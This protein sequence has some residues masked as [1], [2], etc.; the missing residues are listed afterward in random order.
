MFTNSIKDSC[1]LSP[2]KSEGTG[3]IQFAS[4]R[5]LLRNVC[6]KDL[7]SIMEL[8][9]D[10]RIAEMMNGSIP[11]PYSINDA[12]EWVLK[13]LSDSSSSLSISWAIIEKEKFIGSIQVRLSDDRSVARLSY[14]VGHPYWNLGYATEAGKLVIHY[15]F[16]TLKVK[17]IRSEHFQ[18]NPASG[19]VLKKL[20][21]T[22]KKTEIKI[23]KLKGCLEHFDEYIIYN[24]A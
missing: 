13:H 6:L 21:F 22:F 20:G 15:C 11:F 24:N 3:C 1:N 2:N 17:E 14:W 7:D 10:Y 12:K 23:E 8:A 4:H 18:R 5:L 16:E 19:S 9:G